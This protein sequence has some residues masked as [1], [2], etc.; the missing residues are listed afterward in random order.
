M[1]VFP[2]GR[3]AL[4]LYMQRVFEQRVQAGVDRALAPPPA[5]A[6]K[7]ALQLHLRLL[8][9]AHKRVRGLVD[10]LQARRSDLQPQNPTPPQTMKRAAERLSDRATGV[11]TQEAG[12]SSG[13]LMQDMCAKCIYPWL[14]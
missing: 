6:A 3:A 12:W 7:E 13:L 2:S 4:L 8:G 11:D 1:Q 10:Q 14:E 9:E 5:G